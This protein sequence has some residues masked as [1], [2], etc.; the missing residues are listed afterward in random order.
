MQGAQLAF[1]FRQNFF[2]LSQLQ[3]SFYVIPAKAGIQSFQRILDPGFRRGD[4]I[5]WFCNWFIF[6]GNDFAIGQP[7]PHKL[8][9]SLARNI[10]NNL[11]KI[12]KAKWGAVSLFFSI[13]KA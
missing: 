13:T 10:A 2:N 12:P 11:L 3:K 9:Y 1:R 7:C 5:C 4:G 8:G 6:L